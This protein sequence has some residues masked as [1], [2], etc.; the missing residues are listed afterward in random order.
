MHAILAFLR[1]CLAALALLSLSACISS[2]DDTSMARR[3]PTPRDY[4]TEAMQRIAFTGG[5]PEGWRLTG[6]ASAPTGQGPLILVVTG[7]PSWADFWAPTLALATAEQ[8]LLIVPNRPGFATSAPQAAVTDIRR[9]A[10]ALGP[11]IETAGRPVILVGQ[12]YG[13]PIAVLLA[14]AYPEQVAGL[15]IVSGFF[16]EAGPTLRRL[17]F[18]GTLATPFIGRDLKNSLA[19]VRG[20]TPQLE[21]VREAALRLAQPVLVL[22]GDRDDFIPEASARRTAAL[23][24]NAEHRL[25]PGDHFLNAGAEADILA[26]V[27]A[28]AARAGLLAPAP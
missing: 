12:S 21:R 22:H 28:V 13:G 14:S 15:V 4:P 24:P 9:Q 26:A 23:F 1:T 18:Y 10:E 19:E 11:L 17:R 5:G 20:Q 8:R 2:G 6:L 27:D 16:G 3:F 7:S 25:V